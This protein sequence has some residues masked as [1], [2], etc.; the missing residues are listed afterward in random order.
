MHYRTLASQIDA[1]IQQYKQK[2]AESPTYYNLIQKE[3]MKKD[4][5]L[6]ELNEKIEERK[7]DF[8][9]IPIVELVGIAIIKNSTSI[10]SINVGRWNVQDLSLSIA[11]C[12]YRTS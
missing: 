12:Q 1:K 4:K 3:V 5:L 9:S 11:N 8:D 2:V 10:N 7:R 6:K